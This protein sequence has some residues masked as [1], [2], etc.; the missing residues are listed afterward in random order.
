MAPIAE[1]ARRLAGTPGYVAV[2][3]A[4][5]LAFV[6]TANAGI[7]SASRY[8]LAL[9][10]DQLIPSGAARLDKRGA[11][12]VAIVLTGAVVLGALLLDIERLV[13]AAS[14]VV[15][16]AYILS[17]AA[18]LV[19]RKSRLTNYR[20]TFRV[21]FCP[22]LPLAGIAC[23]LYL[24]MDMGMAA[25]EVSAG[26]L[27]LG[28]G[29]Y[30]FYGR[31]RATMEYALQH[32][33]E[34]LIDRNLHTDSLEKELY[35]I[36]HQR[37]ELVYDDFDQALQTAPVVDLDPGSDEKRLFKTIAAAL[38][39]DLELDATA[40]ARRFGV[41]QEEGGCVLTPFTAVP[42]IVVP[43]EKR[44]KVMLV[45]SRD[46]VVI[47]ENAIKAFFVIA[48]SR[49]MRNLHLRALAAIAHVVQH[50]EFEERWLAARNEAQLKDILLLSDR[51]R[52]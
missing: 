50:P 6:T 12:V 26:L 42:H 19:M 34:K 20:P 7:L 45:R 48:G 11:P 33:L 39:S 16:S 23:F 18:V 44:F 29:F 36:L 13:K 15:L 21:P 2:T 35:D 38:E 40:I 28:V 37:D 9:G 10:R 31:K 1:T 41:R 47:D 3:I 49:D 5:L 17:A 14:T 27:L 30:F 43:G 25:V 32:L 24:I 4:A 8:P 52:M 22:W 51:V 46:G